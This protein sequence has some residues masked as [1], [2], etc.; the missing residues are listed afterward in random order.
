MS[1]NK[2]EFPKVMVSIIDPDLKVLFSSPSN[3]TTIKGNNS[4]KLGDHYNAWAMQYFKDIEEEIT[5]PLSE[6]ALLSMNALS[7]YTS[8]DASNVGFEK[9]KLKIKE[10][11]PKTYE[12]MQ[13]HTIKK[14]SIIGA[15]LWLYG[16]NDKNN[17]K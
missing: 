13:K 6:F 10:V 11:A 16:S 5:I 8:G 3:G 15:D 17:V 2:K 4:W 7:T 12:E 14:L 1:N 9:A